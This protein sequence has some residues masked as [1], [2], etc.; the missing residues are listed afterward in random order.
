MVSNA[1]LHITGVADRSDGSGEVLFG[2][3][4]RTAMIGSRLISGEAA[5]TGWNA[6][7]C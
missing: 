5:L 7:R 1:R 6:V 4:A 3:T 2:R